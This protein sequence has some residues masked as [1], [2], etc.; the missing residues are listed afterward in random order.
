MHK[1]HYSTYVVFA[2][3]STCV[4]YIYSIF[5]YNLQNHNLSNVVF[6]LAVFAILAQIAMIFIY[7]IDLTEIRAMD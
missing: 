5:A 6:A 3:K 1:T 7:V 2:C 4:M